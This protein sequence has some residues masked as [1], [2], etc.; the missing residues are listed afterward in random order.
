MLRDGSIGQMGARREDGCR[1]SGFFKF[2]G[3][4]AVDAR[5][6]SQAIGA[7]RRL[8]WIRQPPASYGLHDPILGK[9]NA[10]Q[11][12]KHIAAQEGHMRDSVVMMGWPK[13]TLAWPGLL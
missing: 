12:K 9:S 7:D 13:K 10:A 5:D 8:V 4:S 1:S 11:L 6:S 2:G 3:G